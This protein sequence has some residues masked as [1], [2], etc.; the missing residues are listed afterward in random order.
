MPSSVPRLAPLV[1]GTLAGNSLLVV[2]GPTMVAVAGEFAAPDGAVGQARTIAG[3]AA[4]LASP[5]VARL[6]D[7]AGI[8][9][10]LH[11]GSAL[12]V[13][14]GVAV[15]AA[16]TLVAFLAAH[17]VTGVAVACLGAA[18]LAGVAAFPRERS[19]RAIGYIVGASALAWIVAGPLAGMLTDAI[20]W[21]AAWAVPIALA[22]T[23]LAAARAAATPPAAT[24]TGMRTTL[25]AVLADRRARRWLTAE[26]AAGCVWAADLGY[27]G[28]F[29][30]R[31]HHVSGA[32]A[33]ALL[34][35]ATAAFFL[36]AVRSAALARRL[37]P[38]R[39]I[40]LTSLT[41]AALVACQFTIA[42]SVWVTLTFL[43]VVALCAGVRSSAS[44]RLG[45]AQMADRSSAMTAAQ[46]AVTQA[47]HLLG[48]IAGAAM[49]SVAGDTGLGLA[50]SSGLV[51]AAGLF[52][53]VTDIP[54]TDQRA[55]SLKRQGSGSAASATGSWRR[56]HTGEHAP[57][58][59]PQQR[60]PVHHGR[61]RRGA[62]NG[63][64]SHLRK[65]RVRTLTRTV[66]VSPEAI[67]YDRLPRT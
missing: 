1:L 27:G 48:A 11:T 41:M 60:D 17:V 28:A 38:I 37:T 5:L 59:L 22:V 4:I 9:A 64:A 42:P 10:A 53:R 51:L 31:H 54:H 7:R 8:R 56:R 62:A 45:L 25:R 15:A 66:A 16:P 23:A 26:L 63:Q 39:L 13:L 44:A 46:T 33:G 61:F 3:A 30:I 34:A 49:L 35:A 55:T 32:A 52:A 2:L 21:R 43:C 65:T 20:C 6:I 12:T 47:G 36:G 18:G 50:L 14:A 19:A 40:A 57:S 24:P 58:R 29:V 67:L